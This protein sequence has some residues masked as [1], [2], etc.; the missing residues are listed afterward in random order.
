MN[1]FYKAEEPNLH[2]HIH[3]Q[4]RY[5]QAVV[6]GTTSYFDEEYGHHYALKKKNARNEEPTCK[7]TKKS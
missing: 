2:L 1:N 5:K 4:L 6:I 7:L 3:V